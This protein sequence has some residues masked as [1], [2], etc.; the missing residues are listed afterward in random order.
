MEPTKFFATVGIVT[1]VVIIIIVMVIIVKTIQWIRSF[2]NRKI[3]R[4][5]IRNSGQNRA[6]I[7]S[8][9]SHPENEVRRGQNQYPKYFE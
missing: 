4:N 1:T 9:N 8:N 3:E 7:S 2:F 5:R 6:G